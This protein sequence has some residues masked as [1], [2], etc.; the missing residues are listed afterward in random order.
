MRKLLAAASIAVMS[1]TGAAA[2]P[3]PVVMGALALAA[4]LLYPRL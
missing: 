1:L 4:A 3:F 2:V